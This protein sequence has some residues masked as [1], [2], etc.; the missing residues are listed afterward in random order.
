MANKIIKKSKFSELSEKVLLKDGSQVTY[1]GHIDLLRCR[2]GLLTGKDRLLMQLYLDKANT[3][4]Q[5]ARLAG[6]NEAN[7]A[8]RIHKII[9]RLLDS[10]FITCLRNRDKLTD[11]QIEIARDYLL[12]GLSMEKISQKH[13]VTYYSVRK[14]LRKIQRLTAV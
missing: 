11:L 12:V 14:T 10:Q 8:R 5:M 7:V 2:A 3:Y 6:V 1:N 4:S 13:N 9:R